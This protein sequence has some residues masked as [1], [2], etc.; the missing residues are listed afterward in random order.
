M[1]PRKPPTPA[2][3]GLVA[4]NGN[5]FAGLKKKASVTKKKKTK[6]GKK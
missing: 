4:K 3:L 6:P 1:P 5:P 2:M